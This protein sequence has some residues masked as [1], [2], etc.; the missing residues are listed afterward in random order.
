[1]NSKKGTT[2]KRILICIL[3]FT[4]MVGMNSAVCFGA[5]SSLSFS[6]PTDKVFKLPVGKTY[7]FKIKNGKSVNW[8]TS[9]KKIAY[10]SKSGVVK[11]KKLGTVKITA[12]SKTNKKAKVSKTVKVVR[13]VKS[14]KI[15]SY[16]TTMT[17]SAQYKFKVSVNPTSSTKR[18]T[19]KSSD[20]NVAKVDKYGLVTAVLPGEATIT[21]K[22]VF[23]SKAVKSI[24]VTVLDKYTGMKNKI[25]GNYV[26]DI[27][28]KIDSKNMHPELG[29]RLA[30]SQAEKDVAKLISSEYKKMGLSNVTID[31][32]YT[33]GW[34]F[35]KGEIRY[36]DDF[37][38]SL[39]VSAYQTTFNTH[40]LKN[41]DLVYGGFGTKDDL[42]GLDVVGK[43]VLINTD[44]VNKFWI[45]HPCYEAVMAHGAA[46]VIACE[47]YQQS[48]GAYGL[49]MLNDQQVQDNVFE[50]PAEVPALSISRD[51][52]NALWQAM[53]S[54]LAKGEAPAI[55]T[56]M[57]VKID[58]DSEVTDGV[59]SQNVW[60]EIP[61][62]SDEAIILMAHYDSYFHASLDDADGTAQLMAVAK[63]IKES[64]I[65][66]DKTIRFVHHGA[67][68]WGIDD[69]YFNWAVGAY[70]QIFKLHPEWAKTGFV[71]INSDSF[72]L[73]M[74]PTFGYKT[75]VIRIN[76]PQ[77]NNFIEA[78]KETILPEGYGIYEGAVQT[79]ATTGFEDFAYMLSGIP[80]VGFYRSDIMSQLFTYHSDADNFDYY[81]NV[82]KQDQVA[83][84]KVEVIANTVLAYDSQ[85]LQPV[86]YSAYFEKFADS[87]NTDA[88]V[89]GTKAAAVADA[90]RDFA[91]ASKTLE[92]KI[93]DVNKAYSDAVAA[94]DTAK[95]AELRA[96]GAEI[97]PQLIAMYKQFQKSFTRL[98]HDA[99]D[100]VTPHFQYQSNIESLLAAESKLE[101]SE[102][103]V[104]GAI[105]KIMDIDSNDM[106]Y[107][108]SRTT[109]NYAVDM[110]TG[111]KEMTWAKGLI[112]KPN[113]NLYNTVQSLKA[114]EDATA[115]NVSKELG[116]I[117]DAY[118]D[119]YEYLNEML[120]KE[121]KSFDKLS[122]TVN[123]ICNLL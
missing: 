99:S 8:Q 62:K 82:A 45:N 85:L 91:E 110:M 120:K 7:T 122:N 51:T 102:P 49:A 92:S 33:D 94:N 4:L 30:G 90:A 80:K 112:E 56:E 114:K 118:D 34:N 109:Y 54:T 43:V 84:V 35:T 95:I 69:S 25:D 58:C 78:N 10:V 63:A 29:F 53:D 5:T 20:P 39:Q 11:A 55:G 70:E 9:N 87:L 16:R 72:T 42:D 31:N 73:N 76:A 19:W 52:R 26:T 40:G 115:P 103:D 6:Q 57:P 32:T 60:A 101:A 96:K 17:S 116:S 38:N 22:S 65:K 117:S 61:G 97:N 66:P 88:K 47:D 44:C 100:A 79:N 46:G 67:E 64:G 21:A 108:F 37:S 111:T 68:E 119:Q 98:T 74:D 13:P 113:Q 15:T 48:G 123:E 105:K 12:V 107:D 28:Q 27:I 3:A 121:L 93:I 104:T 77:T 50:G 86:N 106:A 1:M 81:C 2:A 75:K 24:K 14:I 89:G 71:A 36:G 18:V 59:G 41:F 23:N 83:D